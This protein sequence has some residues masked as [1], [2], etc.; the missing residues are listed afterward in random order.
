MKAKER[1]RTF[2]RE[3]AVLHDLVDGGEGRLCRVGSS[4]RAGEQEGRP[5][6]VFGKWV[7]VEEGGEEVKA[8]VEE[9]TELASLAEG[10]LGWNGSTAVDLKNDGA[11]R[12]RGTYGGGL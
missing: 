12:R 7:R 4:Q 5:C 9:V 10:L 6:E 3:V 2:I 8:W 11:V 1:E